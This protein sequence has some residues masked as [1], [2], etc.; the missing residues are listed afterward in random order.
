M[1]QQ[2]VLIHGGNTF[3][4]YEEY[5]DYLKNKPVDLE[6]F[7]SK[8]QWKNSLADDLG[9]DFEVLSP[10]MPNASN[11]Q[12]NEWKILF[13]RIIGLLNDEAI[14]LGHSL[15][16]IFLVKYFSENN[17]SKRVKAALLIGAPFDNDGGKEKLASFCLA[18][19]LDN[20]AR[21]CRQIYLF[22]S[23]DDSVVPFVQLAKYQSALPG[24]Q[25]MIFKDRG[26]FNGESFPELVDLIKKLSTQN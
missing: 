20:F 15:G 14:F 25:A 10:W 11:A 13:E 3:E 6:Y 8:P 2:I 12:F 22:H 16:A 23:E 9:P 19:S 18:R 5:L 24:A 21:Q 26:H 4:V 1:K 17:Y 7:R